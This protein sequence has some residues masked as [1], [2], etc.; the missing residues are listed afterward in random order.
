ML[1]QLKTF[2][3][4]LNKFLTCTNANLLPQFS[5]HNLL[6][7]HYLQNNF[8]KINTSDL[9]NNIFVQEWHI[10]P[11]NLAKLIMTNL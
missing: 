5:E 8:T 11:L 2:N 1:K 4:Y 3:I 7:L 9:L 10:S 6:Y